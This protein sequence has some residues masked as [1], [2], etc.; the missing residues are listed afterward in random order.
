MRD[1]GK[2]NVR[3]R[4]T[5]GV[6][7]SL[8][9]AA[10]FGLFAPA[11]KDALAGIAPLRA[12]GLCY[13]AAGGVAL[14]ALLLRKLAGGRASGRP[15]HSRDGL[16]LAAITLLGGVAGPCLFFAGLGKVAAHQAAILQHLEFALTAAAA[17]LVLGEGPGPRGYAGLSLVGAGLLAFSLASGGDPISS[18]FGL[19]AILIAGAC[20]AWAADNLLAR[21]A[22]DLDPLLVV[23]IK[24]LGAGA[25]ILLVTLEEPWPVSLRAWS[26]VLIA[27]GMGVGVSLVLELLALRRIGAALNAGLFATGPAFGFLWSVV[28]LGE[29]PRPLDLPALA[30]CAAGAAMLSVARH[31]HTHV[32]VEVRHTHR[33]DHLDGH[34][35]HAHDE[36]VP[37]ETSH[38]HEH[39]HEAMTHAHPH[40]HDD[41]HRHRH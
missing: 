35:A 27:G 39:V 33:H 20:L 28:W 38:T 6:A 2:T 36:P 11:A 23:S 41:H 13:A 21:G 9:A 34:H 16:R 5:S 31:L 29:R 4:A 37:P 40:V 25:V 15:V 26:S 8:A 17:V 18:S 12:A 24:G 1:L 7:L 14:V 30:L 10:A 3:R 32:H 22:S 19:G